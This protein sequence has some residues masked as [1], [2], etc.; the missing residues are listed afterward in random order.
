M[1]TSL[2]T[3]AAAYSEVD[4]ARAA[5]HRYALQISSEQASTSPLSRSLEGR[6]HA[7]TKLRARSNQSRAR[8]SPL[9]A[10]CCSKISHHP[11]HKPPLP[12]KSRKVIHAR[13]IHRWGRPRENRPEHRPGRAGFSFPNCFRKVGRL[14]KSRQLVASDDQKSQAKTPRSFTLFVVYLDQLA[15]D[16]VDL[17]FSQQCTVVTVCRRR[18]R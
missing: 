8:P 2:R 18:N 11:C 12:V 4:M 3:R 9:L 7:T 16:P 13:S 10:T 17:S 5:T 14:K 1:H 6:S 15:V